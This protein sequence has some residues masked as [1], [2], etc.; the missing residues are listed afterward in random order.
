[1]TFNTRPVI[2]INKNWGGHA[3]AGELGGGGRDLHPQ[4]L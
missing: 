3:E 4:A 2:G 1:M